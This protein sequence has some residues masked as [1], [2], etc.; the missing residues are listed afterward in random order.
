[1]KCFK[2]H[3]SKSK[4]YYDQLVLGGTKKKPESAKNVNSGSDKL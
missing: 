4:N 3:I 2:N 1:M